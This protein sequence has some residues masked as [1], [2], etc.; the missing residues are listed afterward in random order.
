[1][2]EKIYD[3]NV[4][5]WAGHETGYEADPIWRIDIYECD[6]YYTHDSLPFKVIW[7]S[8]TQADMLTLGKSVEEGG[9]YAGD[10]D[11]WIDPDGILDTYKN[12]P[13]KVRRHLSQYVVKMEDCNV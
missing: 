7:L 3:C 8:K 13:R 10:S 6:N 2:T 4:W 5:D 11:F 9:D 12:I 1:M